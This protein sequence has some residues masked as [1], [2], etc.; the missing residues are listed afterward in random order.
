M[1]RSGLQ[2]LAPII[3]VVIVVII[4]VA[5]LISLGRALFGGGEASPSPTPT[6]PAGKQ[7]L[8]TTTADRSVRMGV[9]GPIVANENAHSY[10][11][12]VSPDTRNMTTY[13]GYDA[14]Q[15]ASKDYGNNAQAYT[16]FVTALDRA[17]LMDGKPLEGEANN[18]DGICSAGYL[19]V[20]EVRQGDNT[21]QQLWTST[22]KGSPG[23]LTANLAQ[24]SRLFNLQ[25]PD[26]STLA[27]QV[28][29][30]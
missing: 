17:K 4:A 16:Q 26:F 28:N 8:T 12:S 18:T 25:I 30:P 10:T 3:L 15:V 22:C 29:L 11:I 24:V 21:V 2:R 13:K 5:A 19:Y 1:N 9:R 14:Q 23:S 7:A 6:T 27:N 20:F